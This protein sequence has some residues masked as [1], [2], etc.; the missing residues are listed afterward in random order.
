MARHR[1]SRFRSTVIA[2]HLAIYFFISVVNKGNWCE[3]KDLLVSYKVEG[4]KMLPYTRCCAHCTDGEKLSHLF[5]SIRILCKFIW[6]VSGISFYTLRIIY[7]TQ[8]GWP[9]LHKNT[10]NTECKIG[11]HVRC[12]TL[13]LRLHNGIA[14]AGFRL[15]GEWKRL[16]HSFSHNRF[17]HLWKCSPLFSGRQ[18]IVI[19]WWWYSLLS[20]S[21]SAL[22]VCTTMNAVNGYVSRSTVTIATSR[23][24]FRCYDCQRCV[25]LYVLEST[26]LDGR[27]AECAGNIFPHT[28]THRKCYCIKIFFILN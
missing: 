4:N 24:Q 7:P 11:K 1:R 5:P 14:C 23:A 25:R 8:Y 13:Y 10:P 2:Q 28:H 12:H 27:Y 17:R 22:A 3:D 18:K 20:V 19:L 9:V 26:R 15:G 16:R 6:R 21:P